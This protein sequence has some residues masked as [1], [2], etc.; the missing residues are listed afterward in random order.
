VADRFWI[1]GCGGGEIIAAVLGSILGVFLR[2][3]TA[4]PEGYPKLLSATLA[5]GYLA[6]ALLVR[7][8]R[9]PGRSLHHPSTT[10]SSLG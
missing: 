4:S 6:S 1:G 5:A 8:R 10:L 7:P 2:R 3:L 9:A